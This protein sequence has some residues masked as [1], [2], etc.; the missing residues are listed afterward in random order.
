MKSKTIVALGLATALASTFVACGQQ[1][2]KA[3]TTQTIEKTN[4]NESKEVV[5]EQSQTTYNYAENIK[6]IIPLRN[7]WCKDYEAC[8]LLVT[9]GYILGDNISTH[10]IVLFNS[11]TEQYYSI[12]LND[13]EKMSNCFDEEKI[14]C[15]IPFYYKG[16][17]VLVP[18]GTYEI[19]FESNDLTSFSYQDTI[20]VA[21]GEDGYK[22][23]QYQLQYILA[24][25]Q[26]Q[27]DTYKDT[28]ISDKVKN[29]GNTITPER[30]DDKYAYE[31][32]ISRLV[33]MYN[34]GSLDLSDEY[35]YSRAEMLYKTVTNTNWQDYYVSPE[36][37]KQTQEI[38]NNMDIE[39]EK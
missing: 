11:E 30:A 2:I 7:C 25:S 19:F 26:D 28:F 22:N 1:P 31:D 38:F 4:T 39:L 23:Q 12:L 5:E 33:Y 10:A 17:A 29:M 15:D 32:P 34:D 36:I 8:G 20:T 35:D 21:K 3:E 13:T 18:E 9:Q 14:N 6:R 16:S 24:D 37:I 27:I